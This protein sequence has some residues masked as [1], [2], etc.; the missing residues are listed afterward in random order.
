MIFIRKN[1]QRSKSVNSLTNKVFFFLFLICYFYSS[2]SLSSEYEKN[3]MTN[4]A[5]EWIAKEL[6]VLKD[7]VNVIP[8]DSRVRVSKCN[9]KIEFDFPFASKET[10]RA[11]CKLPSWQFFLRVTSNDLDTVKKLRPKITTKKTQPPNKTI[12]V[13]VAK[14]NLMRGE[15]L[16][17]DSIQLEEKFKNKMP[18]DV[19]T[20]IEGLENQEMTKNVKAG[21][22]IRSIDI[23]AAKLIKKGDK[24]LFSIVAQGML[25]KATVE[26]L[27]DGRM[28]DQ[29]KLL[30]KDSGQTVIGIVTGKNKVSGL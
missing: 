2:H 12:M 22:V 23:K 20:K 5:K 24:V 25:V 11:R 6:S 28:G 10:V 9:N 3:K 4:S 26:A 15:R 18:V 1:I 13:L 17:E 29:I 7:N 21:Q 8:P 19:F 30:N 14:K 27:Q 16:Q